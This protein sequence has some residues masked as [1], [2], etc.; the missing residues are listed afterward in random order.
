MTLPSSIRLLLLVFR[1]TL[2]L[3]LI[4]VI[5]FVISGLLYSVV[6]EET[7]WFPRL[8]GSVFTVIIW[9]LALL[10]WRLLVYR[11]AYEIPASSARNYPPAEGPDLALGSLVPVPPRGPK[12]TLSA[13]AKLPKEEK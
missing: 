8:I 5:G 7:K 1:V 2:G 12:P 4:V 3:F 13:S 6:M 11:K 9:F 10:V